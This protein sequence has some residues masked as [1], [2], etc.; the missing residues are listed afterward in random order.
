[1]QETELLLGMGGQ[2]EKLR[3]LEPRDWSPDPG[4]GTP[5]AG[6]A[7]ASRATGRLLLGR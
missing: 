6:A 2:R 4:E 5:V 7:A 1:M 3:L